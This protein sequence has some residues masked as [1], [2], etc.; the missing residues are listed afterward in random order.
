[1]PWVAFFNTDNLPHRAP[2]DAQVRMATNSVRNPRSIL[3]T[4]SW[5]H[6]TRSN[7]EHRLPVW[8]A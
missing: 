1:M 7:D 4:L 6:E 8:F 3:R 2:I 5:Y